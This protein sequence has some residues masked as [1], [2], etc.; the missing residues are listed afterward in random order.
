MINKLLEEI[1]DQSNKIKSGGTYFYNV[2]KVK[3]KECK[4]KTIL[5]PEN[6][7]Y[8][9]MEKFK[10][11]YNYP[12]EIVKKDRI[13]EAILNKEDVLIYYLIPSVRYCYY[14]IVSPKDGQIYYYNHGFTDR[15]NT[16]VAGRKIFKQLNK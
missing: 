11:I 6:D 2:K 12:Y 8:V 14:V 3:M 7:F 13:S 9:N 10:T 4:N 1:Y 15:I 16:E 5:I